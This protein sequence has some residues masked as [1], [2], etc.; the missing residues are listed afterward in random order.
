MTH[1]IWAWY[2]E[3]AKTAIGVFWKSGWAFPD[4]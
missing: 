1:S 4:P 2:G 3:A